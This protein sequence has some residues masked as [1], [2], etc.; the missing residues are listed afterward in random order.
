MR[1]HRIPG[2]KRVVI[3]STLDD[4]SGDHPSSPIRM[5]EQTTGIRFF[6]D[7]IPI[8]YYHDPICPRCFSSHVSKNGT[9]M[10]DVQNHSV[11]IQKY[12]CMACSYS[13]ETRPPGYGYGKHIPD[14]LKDKTTGSRVLSSLRKAA[15]MCGIF[16]GITVSHETVRMSVPDIPDRH[17]M[18]SSGY[19]SYDEQ[20]VNI[21]GKRKYRFLLKDTVTGNFHED[22]LEE[23]GEH[24]TMEFILDSLSRFHTGSVITI[25]T[26]GYHYQNAFS[27]V[28]RK[29]LIRIKRQRCLFHIMKDLTKKAYDAGKLKELRVAI[30]LINY[31]LFQTQENLERLGMNTEP[32]SR[33]VSGKSEKESTFMILDMVRDLYS[34]DLII[35]RFLE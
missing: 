14:D 5:E 30:D 10:R 32:V 13:F 33:M 16:L 19:F 9:Y 17:G 23:L 7:N 11:R 1:I 3:T 28:S 15:R 34:D 31:A 24:S 2:I 6:K 21:D 25:T 12:I 20:Y 4:Y 8:L 26:D 29:L 18:E 27:R 35:R 22:I